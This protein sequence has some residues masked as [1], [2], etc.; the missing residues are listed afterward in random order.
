MPMICM[1]AYPLLL[2]VYVIFWSRGVWSGALER[3][4]LYP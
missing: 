3:V 2:L 4:S 1:N